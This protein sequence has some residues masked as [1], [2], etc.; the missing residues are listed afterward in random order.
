[1]NDWIKKKMI[2]SWLTAGTK[3][4]A[5]KESCQITLEIIL[6]V[7]DIVFYLLSR[8]KVSKVSIFSKFNICFFW[9]FMYRWSCDLILK[10][11]M[12]SRC[13]RVKFQELFIISF[14]LFFRQETLRWNTYRMLIYKQFKFDIN[15]M[16]IKFRSSI[17][18]IIIIGLVS[19]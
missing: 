11:E 5:A 15:E 9:F 14:F 6:Y 10:W 16:E 1:M 4:Y 3:S 12:E 19:I 2:A 7:C 17:Q 8:D 18:S 13:E